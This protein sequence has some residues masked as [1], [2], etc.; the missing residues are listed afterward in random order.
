MES[1]VVDYDARTE[2]ERELVLRLASL[3]WRL[4]ADHLDRDRS[5]RDPIGNRA[6]TSSEF[7]GPHAE[8]EGESESSV[9][10]APSMF[11]LKRE[12]AS[13]WKVETSRCTGLPISARDLTCSENGAFERRGPCNAR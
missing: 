12:V 13:D 2:V 8:P 7:P 6:R 3:L 5:A 4:A 1:I 11:D 9:Q 10:S